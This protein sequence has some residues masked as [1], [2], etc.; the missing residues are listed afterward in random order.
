LEAT[1]LDCASEIEVSALA[2][3]LGVRTAGGFLAFERARE[4]GGSTAVTFFGP[5]RF[6]ALFFTVPASSFAFRMRGVS[7][8]RRPDAKGDVTR[9]PLKPRRNV[10]AYTRP[11]P[12]YMANSEVDFLTQ[13]DLFS[14]QAPVVLN[15]VLS[16]GTF[17]TFGPGTIV[18]KQG[19]PG[20]RLYVIKSG[21]LEVVTQPVDNTPQVTVAFLG[22]GEIVGELALL[23]GSPRSATIR[24]PENAE[25]F[26]LDKAVFDDL[27]VSLPGMARSMCEVIARRLEAT[28]LKSRRVET[29]QLSGN[30][31]FFDLAT[32]IQTL[33]GSHQTGSLIV[34]SPDHQRVSEIVFFK[35]N[36]VRAFFQHLKGDDAVFQLF[37]SKPEGEFAFT[38]R[39]VEEQQRT[40]I[41]LPGISLLMESVRMSDEL[42][43][44]QERLTDRKK[45]YK[46]KVSELAWS[47]AESRVPAL[48]VFARLQKGASIEDLEKDSGRCSFWVYKVLLTLQTANQLE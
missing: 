31:Q 8:A 12:K 5:A 13:S 26:R 14:N 18:F 46:S 20:D 36:I 27:M 21:V 23:T 1:T 30:L 40:D 10:E 6:A 15:A 35:G 45:V 44:L 2:A 37:Q 29:K 17:E 4:G 9:S 38:S 3:G 28:T 34:S 11:P 39:E 48:D 42:P 25:L 19:E 7:Q 24:C 43:I 41:T 32:V 47:D 16:Q 33:I 22:V